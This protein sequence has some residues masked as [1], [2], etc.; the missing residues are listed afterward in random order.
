MGPDNDDDYE[1][2]ATLLAV[3]IALF[4][5]VSDTNFTTPDTHLSSRTRTTAACDMLLTY[6]IDESVGENKPPRVKRA[7]R[8]FP[9]PTYAASS[10]CAKILGYGEL[11]RVR[12]HEA[13][14]AVDYFVEKIVSNM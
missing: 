14:A 12:S 8:V 7:R 5:K 6:E 3:A 2:L 10:A 4:A 13:I 1:S 9:C 11:V